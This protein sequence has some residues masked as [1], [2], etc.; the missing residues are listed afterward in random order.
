MDKR[1]RPIR[2]TPTTTC[3]DKYAYRRSLCMPIS[4]SN[5][6]SKT[7]RQFAF[8]ERGDAKMLHLSPRC[9]LSMPL[10]LCTMA[11]ACPCDAA[12]GFTSRSLLVLPVT[13]AATGSR[14]PKDGRG[15]ED[16]TARK[17][18]VRVE[19]YGK[20]ML[21][22][23]PSS[24]SSGCGPWRSIRSSLRHVSTRSSPYSRRCTTSSSPPLPRLLYL[25]PPLVVEAR[26][27]ESKR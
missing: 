15:R 10:G 13:V 11:P 14:A 20:E 9:I 8:E 21:W 22:P 26:Q 23:S 12:L 4:S 17:E 24:P 1:R 2:P 27:A 19:Y 18:D 3:K 5:R 6:T 16:G 7:A 25:P